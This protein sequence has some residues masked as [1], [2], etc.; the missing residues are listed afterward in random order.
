MSRGSNRYGKW[1]ECG[2][3]G[4]R[5]A[6]TPAVDA[7]ASTVKAW[8]PATV[9]EAVAR[10][11]EHS[12]PP[13]AKAIK[14]LIKIVQA[15]RALGKAYPKPKKEEIPKEEIPKEPKGRG[16]KTS[17]NRDL[18]EP[19]PEVQGINSDEELLLDDTDE[20]EK[21]EQARMTKAKS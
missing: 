9:T 3:C 8:E 10:L 2:T 12:I 18:K 20:Y 11:R 7:P 5:M 13:T 21:V 1:M 16:K 17:A 6:Y 14:A 19:L 4:L 15:E